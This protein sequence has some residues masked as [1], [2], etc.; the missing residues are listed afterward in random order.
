MNTSEKNNFGLSSSDLQFAK[1]AMGVLKKGVQFLVLLS[2]FLLPALPC[3][4]R[5]QSKCFLMTQ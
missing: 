3:A 2:I 1:P 4:I 5:E